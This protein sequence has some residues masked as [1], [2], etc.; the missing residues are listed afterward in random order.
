MN[1]KIPVG[2]TVSLMIITAALTVCITMLVSQQVFSGTLSGLS[3]QRAL[4]DK[5]YEIDEKIEQNYYGEVDKEAMYDGA[6]YGYVS[7]LGD[8]YADYAGVEDSEQNAQENEGKGVGIG[9]T[10]VQHPDNHTIYA[11]HVD[12]AG[13]AAQAGIKERDEIIRIDGHDVAEM[14]Y[15]EA[16][17][18]LSGEAGSVVSLVVRTQGE[19]GNSV[20]TPLSV[21][22]SEFIRDSVYYHMS[23]G[24]G[25]VR[26]TEFDEATPDQFKAAVQDLI[27][28]GATGLIF[29]VRNNGGGLVDA[30]ASILD[31]LLPE[32]DIISAT[33]AD[34]STEVLHTSDAAQIE[35]PM[36]V[37]TNE[38][39]ASAAELFA[40]AIRDYNKGV[41]FG[42]KT[43]GKGVMQ[44]TY[45]LSDGST[46][47]FTIAAFNPPSGV[48]FNGVGLTPDLKVNMTDQQKK[49]YYLLTDE[50]DP[51]LAAAV[52]WIV[53]GEVAPPKTED[54]E[55]SDTSSKDDVSPGEGVA[56]QQQS[57]S[58]TASENASA[59]SEARESGS[60]ASA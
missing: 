50:E 55:T 10:A 14:E 29:D 46:V 57:S 25:Y 9:I 18:M 51:V 2:M 43:Y 6:A 39:T 42:A 23:G 41:L 13:P 15:S 35:L 7:G 44:R 20:E 1:K 45:P 22:R 58:E 8:P 48:N 49:Y 21:T 38:R 28:Q 24:A 17:Q 19:D 33:Y 30:A 40:A 12:A 11:V 34:G 3:K 16:V 52:N 27:G 5:L 31:F 4:F 26:I 53:T 59:D 36:A 47:K 54:S 56:S 37:L 60:D 32:G